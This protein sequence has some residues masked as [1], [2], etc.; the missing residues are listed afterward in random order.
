MNYSSVND[1]IGPLWE[2]KLCND[3]NDIPHLKKTN[4][5]SYAFNYIDYGEEKVQPGELSLGKFQEYNCEEIINKMKE[6][7]H[8]IQK[9]YFREK[10]DCT[11]Y[12]IALVIDNVTDKKDYHF[13][14]QDTNGLWSHKMGG[15]DISKVDARGNIIINPEYS[16]RDYSK[17]GE[18]EGEHDYNL[19]CGYFSISNKEGPIVRLNQ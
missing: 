9:S 7:Y 8:D 13:Y 18:V 10:L 14:R 1:C 2:P 3:I 12:K 17:N 19:F 11:R 16:D 5:Y 4:C 6:D 15:N